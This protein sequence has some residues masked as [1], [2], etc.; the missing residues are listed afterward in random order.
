MTLQTK[1]ATSVALFCVISFLGCKTI[2]EAPV[3]KA[4]D[5]TVLAGSMCGKPESSISDKPMPPIK[6]LAPIHYAV[7]SSNPKVQSYFDQGI[8]LLY[9]FEYGTAYKSFKVARTLDPDCAMCAWGM[10]MALGPNINNGDMAGKD[11]AEARGLVAA[12]LTQPGL[13]DRDRALLEALAIRYAPKPPKDQGNVYAEKY[14]DALIAASQRWPDDDFVAVLAAEAAMTVR[15]W[16]YWEKGGHVALPW[17]GKAMTLVETVLKRSPDQPEAIHLYIHLTENSDNPG[18]AEPYADRLGL[19]ASNSPHLIHMPSHTYYPLGR[20]ADSIR[21]NEQAIKAD[22]GMARDLGESPVAFGYYFHHSRFIMSAA[23]QVGDGATA[24]RIAAELEK[25]VPLDKALKSEWSESTLA[26]A[27]QA[28]AQFEMPA[29][30]LAIKAP[31][32]RLKIATLVWHGV[33]AEAYARSGAIDAARKELSAVDKASQAVKS[34]DW[35]GFVQRI[36]EMAKGRVDLA[37]GNYVAAAGHFRTAALR[38]GEFDYSEPPLWDQPAETA[39]GRT[40]LMAGDAAGA[41]VAFD[42]AL[43]MR[44]GNAYALWGRAQAEAKLGDV[45][46]SRN[47]LTAFDKIWLGEKDTINLERL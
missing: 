16:D 10:A 13:T 12:A 19:L 37:A 20:F 45:A 47:S 34:R 35:Q 44:P 2:P 1:L 28:R 39:L 33:R 5:P 25:Q 8:S 23:Q 9:G 32:R 27:L 7:S 43:K 11:S 46:T 3:A 29:Q 38:E 40:L 6:G 14:A 4:I 26:L 42:Q 22:E 15:P 36:G 18:R 21:I 17:G 41:K 24:L 31:D 30:I